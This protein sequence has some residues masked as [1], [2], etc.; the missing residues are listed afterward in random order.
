MLKQILA[1]ACLFC[2]TFVGVAAPIEV[3]EA[4]AAELMQVSGI[5]PALSERILKAR[6]DA[7]FDDWRDLI[8]RVRGIGHKK[9]SQF[10]DA[11]LLVNGASYRGVAIA[12]DALEQARHKTAEQKTHP[13]RTPQTRR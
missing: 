8:A 5:G 10:S 11:G 12:M 9:A 13:T 7:R 6:S 3:N 1:S 2:A 4:S